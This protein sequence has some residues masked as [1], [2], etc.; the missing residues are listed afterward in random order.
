MP[1]DYV[2]FLGELRVVAALLESVS[3]TQRAVELARGSAQARQR[4]RALAQ[5][6][7]APRGQKFY[8]R[9]AI[10]LPPGGKSVARWAQRRSSVRKISPCLDLSRRRGCVI[11]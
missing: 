7:I 3:P 8:P 2:P 11:L 10:Y 6:H 1:A 5:R 4:L 9:G